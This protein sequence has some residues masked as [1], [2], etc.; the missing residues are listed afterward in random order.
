MVHWIC[1]CSDLRVYTHPR[2]LG[3]VDRWTLYRLQDANVLNYCTK[4]RLG[5][6]TS[7]PSADTALETQARQA[8]ENCVDECLHSWRL[9]SCP[10]SL[11][12]MTLALH[13]CLPHGT[14]YSV[15]I[16]AIVRIRYISTLEPWDITW[17]IA[18][19]GLWLNVECDIGIV[20]ACLPLLRPVFAA[21]VPFRLFRTSSATSEP[22]SYVK[23]GYALKRLSRKSMSDDKYQL[24]QTRTGPEQGQV[25]PPTAKGHAG[26]NW[27]SRRNSLDD[28]DDLE[29]HVPHAQPVRHAD[30]I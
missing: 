17:S 5:R 13:T 4:C 18:S 6:N 12:G 22:R 15:C 7:R 14:T 16:A 2:I 3:Q 1:S 25:Q 21:I 20:C 26:S 30:D 11:V 8:K 28:D 29:A 24:Q 23:P 27:F 19:I 10:L 9:V